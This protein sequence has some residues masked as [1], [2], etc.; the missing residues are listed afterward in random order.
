MWPVG[1]KC[2]IP[3]LLYPSGAT[4]TIAQHIIIA[5]FARNKMMLLT[6]AG[7]D[8]NAERRRRY[9]ACA[10]FQYP[11]QPGI[12]ARD[13]NKITCDE[14]PY[15]TTIE[16]VSY[17]HLDVYKRQA[18]ALPMIGW[19]TARSAA[20][21]MGSRPATAMRSVQPPNQHHAERCQPDPRILQLHPGCGWQSAQCDRAGW[22]QHVL[23][24]VSYTHLDVYKR[25]V[26][27]GRL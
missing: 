9:A 23:G 27:P 24:P 22:Q 25:Q 7:S 1:T 5:Q 10:N 15:A 16:A 26:F 13:P 19:A 6:Y 8:K 18:Q 12:G 2:V 21:P 20:C 3:V 17:T 11:L 14:Y 4:P